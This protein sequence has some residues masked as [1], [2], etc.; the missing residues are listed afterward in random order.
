M[1]VKKRGD[2]VFVTS[3]SL[4]FCYCA[5]CHGDWSQTIMCWFVRSLRLAISLMATFLWRIWETTRIILGQV[6]VQVNAYCKELLGGRLKRVI[7]SVY[8]MTLG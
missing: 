2:R 5:R 3:I 7:T 4:I 6:Y 8:R 1:S